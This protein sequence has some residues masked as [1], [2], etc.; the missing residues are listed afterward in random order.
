MTVGIFRY[1]PWMKMAG[2]AGCPNIHQY[3]PGR[4]TL[5]DLV[6][7]GFDSDPTTFRDPTRMRLDYTLARQSEISRSFGDVFALDVVQLELGNWT[8]PLY[9]GLGRTWSW[10]RIA[11]MGDYPNLRKF[12]RG[13]NASLWS[14]AAR[15]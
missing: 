9:S 14:S 7:I 8:G 2:T 15:N 3:S 4:A 13:S 12:G 1:A 11:G 6:A 5:D 10:S